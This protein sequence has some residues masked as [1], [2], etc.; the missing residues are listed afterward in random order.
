M[1]DL[2]QI[3]GV[4]KIMRAKLFHA[5]IYCASDL[6]NTFPT[7]YETHRIKEFSEAVIGQEITLQGVL[8][9]DSSV[10]RIR[11]RLTK[12][13]FRIASGNSGFQVV[14]FNR[15]FLHT[16]LVKGAEVVITGRFIR[17][18][19][20]FTASEVV[21]KNRYSEGIIPI[22]RVEGFSSRQFQNLVTSVLATGMVEKKETIP[23]YLII[24]NQLPA[25]DE[26]YGYVHNPSDMSE[27]MSAAKRI[28]YTEFLDFCLRIEA[29]R[30]I[31]NRIK[32]DPMPY[33]IT[34]VRSFIS[35]LPFELTLDQKQVTNE[36]FRDFKKKGPMSRLLQGDV[37]SGKTVC[38]AIAAVATISAK[39]Q[40][41]IMAP[42]EILAFQ[43]Y[44]N[45]L[46]MFQKAK[47]D[48]ETVFLSGS[49][50]NPDRSEIMEKIK[51]VSP[52]VI[53]GT[54]ALIQ[55]A[56]Q[57]EKLGLVIVDEQQRFGVDQR[58]ALREK[59][60]TPDVLFLSATPIPRTLAITIFGDMDV[61][62]IHTMPSGR[63]KILSEIVSYD[64]MKKV[65]NLV[66]SELE[67]GNQAYFIV[68]LIEKNDNS[69][70]FSVEEFYAEIKENFPGELN[71][72]LMHGKMKGEEKERILKDFADKKIRILVSTTVIEVGM[73]VKSATVMVVLN[74]TRFGLSQLHQLRGRVG[75]SNKQSYCF[76]VVD[77][78]SNDYERLSILEKTDDGFEIS[79]ADLENRGPGQVFGNEQSG[80]PGFQMA[81]FVTDAFLL[82]KARDDVAKVASSKDELSQCLMKKALKSIDTFTLD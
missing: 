38:A 74:A 47:I 50:K 39:R 13:S 72:G 69:S 14:I 33:D 23:G 40:V 16:A 15:E 6:V 76:F 67:L 37:G 44:E 30:E 12:L 77:D 63:K 62:S 11:R 81:N 51:K 20:Q 25:A 64:E 36:I 61:S 8:D 49:V 48:C 53:I 27:A 80:I 71:T 82:E 75:R 45:F 46:A 58:K 10:V 56:T 28:K 3:K 54:H 57:F 68:P 7:Q 78:P 9:I 19:A 1:D 32:R 18:F 34:T 79:K 29:R 60:I 24:E 59:G 31:G 4:G 21:L 17:S 41:A 2:L 65:Y 26:F 43:H 70:L 52:L 35:S 5:G 55:D 22:Y 42:T 66:S 73:D